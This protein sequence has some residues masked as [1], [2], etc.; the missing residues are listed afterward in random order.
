[1]VTPPIIVEI[2]EGFGPRPENV[3]APRGVQKLLTASVINNSKSVYEFFND[4]G[5]NL[6][7]ITHQNGSEVFRLQPGERKSWRITAL[8]TTVKSYVHKIFL[9][10]TNLSDNQV[11]TVT[12]ELVSFYHCPK[13]TSLSPS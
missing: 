2:A 8:F 13:K 7:E 10:A 5:G 4:I 6:G 1:M 3:S 11:L 12:K 9:K